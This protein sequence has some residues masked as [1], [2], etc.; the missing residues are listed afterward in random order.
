MEIENLSDKQNYILTFSEAI[1]KEFNLYYKK[2]GVFIEDLN[3]LDISLNKRS[4]KDVNPTFNI[5]IDKQTTKVFY[6]KAKTIASQIGRFEIVT[7]EEYYNPSKITTTD[8]YIIFAFILITIVM[9]NIYS[10]FLT[11]DNTYMYYILYVIASVIFSNMHSGSYLILGFDGWNEGLHVVGAF[12]ILFLLLFSNKFLDLKNQ[13]P[14]VHKFFMFSAIVF[15]LFALLIYNNIAYSSVLFN[16]YSALFFMILFF[17]VFKIFLKGVTTVKYYLIALLIYAPLMGLMIAT[18][19]TFLNYSGFT[20]HSF[21]AGALIEI[22]F[23]TLLL[24]SKY[25]SLNLEKIKIQDEL[26]F[27]KN[28]NEAKLK[29]EIEKQTKEIS[30]IANKFTF[31]TDNALA[32]FWEIDLDTNKVYFSN[33]WFEFLGYEKKDFLSITTEKTINK[34]IHKEDL[35]SVFKAVDDFLNGKIKKY[36]VEFRV[37]HKDGIFTWVNASGALY[38]NKF[39]G[40]HIDIDDIKNANLKIIEQS[41]M[42]SMGEMIG[43]IAH[44]WRQPLSVI[45]TASTGMKL[46]KEFD[47]LSDKEFYELC[48]SINN[49]AQYLSKTIDDFKNF[50]KGD[51]T[52][53]TFVLKDEIDSFLNLVDGSIKSNN[54]KIILNL[55]ETIK[56]N[57]FQNE[58]T[59]SLINI[60]NNSKDILVEK[61]IEEKL[62]FISTFTKKEK[63]I[64]KIKDNGGGVP[65]DIITKI[66]EPYFTTK[67]QSQGTG[68]GLHMTYNLIVDGMGGTIEVNNCDYEYKDDKYTGAEFII[69]L[70]TK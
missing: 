41:K 26:I 15:I 5:H 12:V 58:L 20:R 44:Q 49:N 13:L 38:K 61:K 46:Q 39:F 70:P 11:K 60:F 50:I 24:A 69:N 9:L 19:N 65:K 25:R 23:F 56:I 2:D 66:F 53:N 10:Y 30:E 21:L 16:I 67:H 52:K 43:N 33:G 48:D 62:I 34:I 4:I 68:L 27:E 57:G 40:F 51:M 32:G 47:M 18:F 29:N 55:D 63:A 59:Q 6:I 35:D 37:L 28:N 36:N 31:A 3:G 17:A 42:V 45:A 7:N 54:I 22:I 64:I 14:L 8:I 1:W